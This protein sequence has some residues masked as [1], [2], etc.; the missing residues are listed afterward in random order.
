MASATIIGVAAGVR[1][2]GGLA[3]A[4]TTGGVISAKDAGGGVRV[5]NCYLGVLPGSVTWEDRRD[6]LGVAWR[7]TQCY[8]ECYLGVTRVVVLGCFFFVIP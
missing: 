5:G 2:A 1:G 7:V 6:C 3:S 4:S 8:L